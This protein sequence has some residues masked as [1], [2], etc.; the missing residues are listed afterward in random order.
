MALYE[1][2]FDAGRKL[3]TLIEARLPPLGPSVLVLA[4]LRGGV[5]VAF[6]V[7]EKLQLPLDVFNVRKLGVPGQPEL[8]LGALAA[9]GLM[10]LNQQLI[11]RLGISQKQIDQVVKS[12][13]QELE[14]REHAYRDDLPFPDL[15]GLTVLLV[16]DGLATG[17]T[18]RAAVEALRQ[19]EPKVIIVAVPVAAADTCAEVGA[20]VEEIICAE[21]PE[22]FH[23]VGMWYDDFSQ[24]SDSEVHELLARARRRSAQV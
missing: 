20:V 6:E 10:Y 12:E 2:R 23:G 1:D 22:P 21:T 3:A 9:G 14:R 18:M 11:H 24:T 17:A 19:R 13:E 4:L 7:A 15:D 16:D 8:A 5:P